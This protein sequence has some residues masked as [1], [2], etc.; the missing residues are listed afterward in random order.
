MLKKKKWQLLW[1]SVGSSRA[2]PSCS[3]EKKKINTHTKKK[4]KM[5]EKSHLYFHGVRA[6]HGIK[7][8]LEKFFFCGQIRVW[9]IGTFGFEWFICIKTIF[10]II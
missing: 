3:V 7:G 8:I 1:V 4:K 6:A 10:G 5:R 2:A 9:C